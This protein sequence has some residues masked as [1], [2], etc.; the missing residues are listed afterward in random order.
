VKTHF[1]LSPQ[2]YE[3]SRSG[4]LGRRR[5]ELVRAALAGAAAP[6]ATVLEIGCGPGGLLSELAF[7]RPELEFVGVDSDPR[8]IDYARSANVRE[9]VRYE[10]ADFVGER[11]AVLADF[12]YGI[13]VLHHVH[14]LASF[15]DGV[16]A[17]LGAG[18]TWLVI[19]PN[20]FHP[21]IFW[22][23]GRMRRA[24]LDED[25]FRPWVAEPALRAAGFVVRDRRYAFLFPGCVQSVP[26]PFARIE[27][28]LERLR[29]LGGS[30]VYRLERLPS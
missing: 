6:G 17:A 12:A 8:M 4:H 16:R 27:S 25:H 13:D 11:P 23:Q 18:G 10:L 2:E 26:R 29:P 3:Q 5:L 1:E 22:S 9:N 15:L 21:Y 20:V 30:V 7:K 24:G 14:D 28:M 19:E